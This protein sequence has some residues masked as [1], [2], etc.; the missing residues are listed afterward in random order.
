MKKYAWIGM[1]FLL[2]WGCSILSVHYRLG[3]EAALNRDWDKAVEFFEQA[4]LE[5]PKNSYARLALTR[6][7]IAASLS[8][9][10][11][12][13]MLINQGKTDEALKEYTIARAYDPSNFRL[14][15]EIRSLQTSRTEPEVEGPLSIEP[16]V[17]LGV[18]TEPMDLKI[19][20]S[21]LKSIFEALGK[22]AAINVIFDEMYRD[23]PF[24]I[25]LEGMSFEQA[26]KSI[27]L[28]SKCFYRVVNEKTV[29]IVPDRPDKRAQYELQVIRTFYLSNIVAQDIHSTLVQV[30][31]TNYRGPQV[32]VDKLLNSVTIRD[33]PEVVELADKLIRAWDK[34]RA[35]VM[36]DLQIME[37]SRT[38]LKDMGL[39]LSNYAVGFGYAGKT[40]TEGWY[41]LDTID[42]GAA[43]NFQISLPASLLRFLE[44][45]TDTKIIAQSQLRGMGGEEMVYK[46]GDQVPV[47][48]T[49][50][51]PIA[52]GGVASQP[53][54]TYEYKDVGIDIK[55]TPTVH[56]EN[57]IT[58]AL[59]ISVKSI[60]GAGIADI[61][62]LSTREVKNMLRLKHGETNLLAGL[63]Q[64]EERKTNKGIIGLKNIPGLGALLS[65]TDQEIKQRDV[66]MTITPYILRDLAITAKDREPIWVNFDAQPTTSAGTGDMAVRP[67]FEAQEMER[68]RMAVEAQEEENVGQGTNRLIFSPSNFEISQGRQFRITLTMDSP[69]EVSAFSIGLSFDPR[70][71]E[72][73]QVIPGGFLS[74][75]SDNP[76]FLSDIDNNGGMS[77]VAFTNPVPGKGVRGSGRIVTYVF[78]SKESGESVVSISS[79]TVRSARGT[80]L[81]FS[82]TPARIIVK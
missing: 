1:I 77:T 53:V 3:T 4:V 26:L 13:R 54:V 8:H 67:D 75:V 66:I 19:M 81:N 31:R 41:G 61:P 32:F 65:R 18:G 33:I 43:Q 57:E 10:G 6:A 39:E 12:A 58:L 36:L 21:N 60:S 37:V 80:P 56:H 64:D 55:I 9:V 42:F 70:I 68:R 47:P 71:L 27:C 73:K 28:A 22:Y 24:S 16:P 63:L 30:L 49:T 44:S 7:K 25:N 74:Q 62:I 2:A 23:M 52:A 15:E 38:K 59:D 34:P 29:I 14:V 72:L 51:N 82:H 17:R 20:D 35:E 79:L 45:D 5:T 46:V 78:E 76:P 40:E 50:F 48:Q 11:K 69:A